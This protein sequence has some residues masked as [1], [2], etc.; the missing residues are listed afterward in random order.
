MEKFPRFLVIVFVSL[1]CYIETGLFNVWPLYLF[2]SFEN[3]S[4]TE[5]ANYYSESLT[6]QKGHTLLHTNFQF[7]AD[8]TEPA[9]IKNIFNNFSARAQTKQQL[10]LNAL[11]QYLV[12]S[13]NLP[14]R[15][16]KTDI[17]FPFHNFW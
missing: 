2:S 5:K 8:D 3:D 12:N 13:R 11:A 14:I 7:A 1:L 6:N 16:E 17:I 10:F 9:T 15:F 4:N